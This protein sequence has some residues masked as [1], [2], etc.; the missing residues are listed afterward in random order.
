MSED[1]VEDAVEQR[2]M[3]LPAG[4]MKPLE[5]M[6]NQWVVVAETGTS[7]YDIQNPH[8][9]QMYAIRLKRNDFV[10]VLFDD[11][12]F[13]GRY[14]VRD[15][16]RTYAVLKELE[17]HDLTG[18]DIKKSVMD[19]YSYKWRGPH[20]RHCIVRNKDGTVMTEHHAEKVD[21][22]KWLTENASRLI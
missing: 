15:C 8:Y 17:W 19:E 4:R 22:L 7:R 9:M 12:T 18:E 1:I 20:S 14:I 3:K 11:E 5:F 13:Y 16:S 2:E 10:H 6:M 21:A